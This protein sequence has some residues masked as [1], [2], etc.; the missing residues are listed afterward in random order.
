[1]PP[2]TSSSQS[3]W[4]YSLGFLALFRRGFRLDQS[5][6]AQEGRAI[7]YFVEIHLA[8]LAQYQSGKPIGFT[9]RERRMNRCRRGSRSG[10]KVGTD[11]LATF[12]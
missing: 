1:M 5:R 3:L 4:P 7:R 2:S 9:G 11:L 12:P 8:E 10:G 6:P